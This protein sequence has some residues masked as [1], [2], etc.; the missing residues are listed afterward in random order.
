[1][2][3]SSLFLDISFPT[4]SSVLPARI[5]FLFSSFL[6]GLRV[7]VVNSF[8]LFLLV[9][10]LIFLRAL[11]ALRVSVVRPIP[12]F[13]WWTLDGLVA[14]SG[15]PYGLTEEEIRIVEGRQ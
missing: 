12:C 6:R 15:P 10:V 8:P 2:S 3:S 13:S 1:M 11:R 7:S 14:V 5:A 4:H 9:T